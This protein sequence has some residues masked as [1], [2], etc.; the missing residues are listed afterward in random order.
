MKKLERT[1]RGI[2]YVK[3]LAN[4]A[5][6]HGFGQ[7]H[8]EAIQAFGDDVTGSVRQSVQSEHRVR[9][10]RAEPLFS[11][12]VAGIGQV[13]LIKEED[14]GDVYYAGEDLLVPDFRL[15]LQDE[16]QLLVEVKAQD[17]GGSFD[18]EFKLSDSCVQRLS[19]YAQLTNTPLAIAIFWEEI[20]VWTLNHLKAFEPG[21]AGVK[22]WSINFPRAVATSEMESLGDC[23][24]ATRAPLVFRLKVDPELSG[25]VPPGGGEMIVRFKRAQLLSQDRPLTGL[26]AKI[27]W[28]LIWFGRWGEVDQELGVEE[29]RLVQIDFIIGPPE[30]TDIRPDPMDMVPIGSLSQMISQAYLSGAEGTIHTTSKGP[31]LQPGYMGNFIPDNF[32]ELDIPLAIFHIVPNYD[33]PR[34]EVVDDVKISLD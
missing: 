2:D 28:R 8:E 22:K 26:A 20:G 10:I 15:V 25:P 27:A 7:Y 29:G 30:W 13:L 1:D 21:E 9:G 18:T 3:L 14:G 11:S 23:T 19:R 6:K 34:E 5:S 24:V 32:V 33:F 17:L 12:V 16:R 4:F 31:V